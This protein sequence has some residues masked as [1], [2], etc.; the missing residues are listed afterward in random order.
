MNIA[1]KTILEV[2]G[3]ETEQGYALPFSPTLSIP[4]FLNKDDTTVYPEIRVSPFI[5]QDEY[6]VNRWTNHCLREYVDY[7]VGKFQIDIYARELSLVNKI[8]E[9]LRI[10]MYEFFNLEIYTFDYN[11]YFEV[12]DDHYKNISYGI[13]DLFNDIYYITVDGKQLT[14]TQFLD[15]LTDDSFFVNDE[16]LYV[17]TDLDLTKI[18]IAVITQ[19]RLLSNHD[20]LL[21]RGIVYYE[22]SSAKNLS[23]L[24]NNEVERLS[25]DI[26]V[27][28]GLKNQRS[29]IP[30]LNK[31][32]L[33]GEN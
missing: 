22:I 11:E 14:R 23:E 7:R 18:K 16:A 6:H 30:K 25:F 5:Q 28:F 4:I 24:Q 3:D 17:K 32:M 8:Y 10:R 13:G 31:V 19:G 26:E 15:D 27:L 29:K 1:I 20:S 21:N 9:V 33:N 2:L 12:E